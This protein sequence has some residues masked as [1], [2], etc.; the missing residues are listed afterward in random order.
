V[1]YFSSVGKTTAVAISSGLSDLAYK[2]YLGP[3][4]L[5]S[6]TL[7]TII[8]YEICKIIIPLQVASSSESDDIPTKVIKF[9]LPKFFKISTFSYPFSYTSHLFL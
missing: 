2:S 5:K 1:S 3:A 7:E 8:K 6:M 4:Y 9:I